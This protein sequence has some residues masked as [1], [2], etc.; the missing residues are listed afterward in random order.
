MRI[1]RSGLSGSSTGGSLW[2]SASLVPPSGF[3]P[4]A[5]RQ[6]GS[7]FSAGDEALLETFPASDATSP[8]AISRELWKRQK[9]TPFRS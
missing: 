3:R 2:R 9:R 6:L 8:S 7:R 4:L 5:W 1:L